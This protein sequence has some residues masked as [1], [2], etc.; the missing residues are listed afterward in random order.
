MDSRANL[1][2]L[3][4]GGAAAVRA[5]DPTARMVS[6]CEVVGL[7]GWRRGVASSRSVLVGSGLLLVTS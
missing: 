2:G 5:S 1:G 4:A 7:V 3:C 6:R